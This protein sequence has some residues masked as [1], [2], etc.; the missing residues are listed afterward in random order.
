[1]RSAL[2]VLAAC[3]ALSA[4]NLA[5]VHQEPPLPVP[6]R[7]DVPEDG[8][9]ARAA[10]SVGWRE[11]FVDPQ[12]KSLIAQAL[13]NNR[14]L[15]AAVARVEQARALYRIQDA[16]RWPSVNASGGAARGRTPLSP[17][18]GGGSV[19]ADQYNVQAAVSSF[20]IDFWGR[21]ANLSEAARRRFLATL[22]AE[23]AFRLS[24]VA[25]VGATYYA[26][27]SGQDGIDLAQRTLDARSYGLEIARMRLDAGV[28]SLVD[29]DQAVILATQAQGQLAELQRSVE[30]LNNQLMILVGGPVS[31]LLPLR[32]SITHTEQFGAIAVGLPSQLLARR[33]D[34]LQAEQQLRAAEA[35]IGAAR[36]AFF[37]RISLTGNFGY[38]STEMSDL[39]NSGQK[40]W[41]LG[42]V[43]GLPIFD[44]GQRAAV[45]AQTRARREELV[46]T[47]QRT[48]QGAFAEVSD[49]LIARR[50][51]SEQIAAQETAVAAQQ[52][53][54]ETAEL[55]YQNGISIYLE[56]MD[57]KRNQFAAEQQLIQLRAAALQNGVSL[58]VALGGGGERESRPD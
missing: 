11:F 47:Y 20:E 28:T 55:R 52:R 41:S 26:I 39:L 40:T 33:P 12:L 4:C 18:M 5:P 57:A 32:K 35:D 58:Y 29:Y 10:A 27:L 1:M 42:G 36:A 21:V 46:A 25:N 17:A 53:L 50:R 31:G 48:V 56:V 38:V 37:P 7:F 16:D 51:L 43:I 23:R 45:L 9:G 8:A 6:E 30:Q 15:A 3:C 49:A 34:I 19:I 44:A 13:A 24:L 54:S 14:D 22:E 2:S